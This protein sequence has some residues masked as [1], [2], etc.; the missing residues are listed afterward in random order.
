MTHC[1]GEGGLPLDWNHFKPDETRGLVV[2]GEFAEQ[3]VV[4]ELDR[5]LYPGS[6]SPL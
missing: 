4:A 5:L 6:C 3:C 2:G 1:F